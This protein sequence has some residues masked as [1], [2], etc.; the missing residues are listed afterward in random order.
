MTEKSQLRILYKS[1]RN[2][3]NAHEKANI[4]KRILTRFINSDLYKNHSTFLIYVSVG[5]EIDTRELIDFMQ[6][7]GK[8]VA[9][10]FCSGNNMSFCKLDSLDDLCGGAFGIPTVKQKNVLYSYENAL[11]I[12]PALS[13]DFNGNR[14]GYGGGFYD[15]F[16]AE[17]KITTVALC[18]ERCL[19]ASLPAE[20]F[21][22]KINYLLT[23]NSLKKLYHKEVSTY[24]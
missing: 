15:R 10:P 12:V 23:E 7:D 14:L 8:N 16:L 20:R 9:I 13:V 3:L 6:K 5:S 4:D 18:C 24:E 11:C 2:S 19:S 17:N 22:I 21:D 1:V